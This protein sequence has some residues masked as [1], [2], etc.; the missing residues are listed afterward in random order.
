MKSLAMT[1]SLQPFLF[2]LLI[3]SI[4]INVRFGSILLIFD[5]ALQ[6]VIQYKTICQ[7][8]YAFQRR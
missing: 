3:T 6:F 8:E 7:A 2:I 1:N 5:Y 4:A